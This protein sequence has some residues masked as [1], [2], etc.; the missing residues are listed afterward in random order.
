LT[1]YGVERL[2][3]WAVNLHGAIDYV[4]DMWYHLNLATGKF[5]VCATC[6]KWE[7]TGTLAY[8]CTSSGC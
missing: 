7:A 4:L 3:G 8:L 2:V 6:R 1:K 5:G